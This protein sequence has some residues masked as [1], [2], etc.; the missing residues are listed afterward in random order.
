MNDSP[1]PKKRKIEIHQ[2]WSR[3]NYTPSVDTFDLGSLIK[4][5][6]EETSDLQIRRLGLAKLRNYIE[7]EI[8][9]NTEKIVTQ[10]ITRQ[11]GYLMVY[12]NRIDYNYEN[13]MDD[14]TDD[15]L[16]LNLSIRLNCSIKVKIDWE[17]EYDPCGNKRFLVA[18]LVIQD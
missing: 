14:S 17:T 15:L 16:S 12:I 4:N 5:R 6:K 2:N 8:V 13:L 1:N 9:E 11:K 10:I 18:N 3:S 7:L